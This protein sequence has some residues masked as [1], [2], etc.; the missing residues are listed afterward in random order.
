T[1]AAPT[2]QE[3]DLAKLGASVMHKQSVA[4][5]VRV[6][7][8]PDAASASDGTAVGA[9]TPDA[10]KPATKNPGGRPALGDRPMT[11]AERSRRHRAKQA[12]ETT[13]PSRTNS[14]DVERN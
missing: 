5:P 14:L 8:L 1:M 4:A 9:A 3:C 7:G 11:S 6:V 10:T 2:Q 12:A 13:E